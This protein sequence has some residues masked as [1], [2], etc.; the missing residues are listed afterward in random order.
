LFLLLI[1]RFFYSMTSWHVG[2]FNS[3]N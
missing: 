2:T 3:A 1:A